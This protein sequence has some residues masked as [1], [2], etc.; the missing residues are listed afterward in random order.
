MPRAIRLLIV[1]F[2]GVVVVVPLVVVLLGPA[3]IKL[4]K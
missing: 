3:L 2:V 1:W 4:T